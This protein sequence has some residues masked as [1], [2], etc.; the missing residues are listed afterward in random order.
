ML[1]SLS[2]LALVFTADP[3]MPNWGLTWN[4]PDGCIRTAELAEKIEQRFK[5]PLFGVQPNFRLEGY[6][7]A[8]SAGFRARLTLLDKYG[9]VL[10]SRELLVIDHDCRQLDEQ[11]VLVS[12]LLM[13]PTEHLP[14]SPPP[15]PVAR[16]G[17]PALTQPVVPRPPVLLALNEQGDHLLGSKRINLATFYG[18]TS[19]PDLVEV[20]KRL[21]TGRAVG[22][23]T[24]IITGVVGASLL[25]AA[26]AGAGCVAYSGSRA[27][28]GSC[29]QPSVGLLAGG[30]ISLGISLVA[31]V[32]LLASPST[33]TT[34]D[35]DLALI[36]TANAK[37]RAPAE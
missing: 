25:I 33:P 36:A 2:L 14:P 15:P 16:E 34:R 27:N 4:A 32:A 26:A 17:A 3:G 13:E 10:G 23:T 28:P 18:L 6:A 35:E 11:L 19:R 5:R 24:A 30:G 31:I 22:L 21:Q 9:T 8:T 20:L 1:V 7:A 37:R 29:V 12:S